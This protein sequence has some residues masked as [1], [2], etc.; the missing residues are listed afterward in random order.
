MSD[1][2][3]HPEHSNRPNVLF[4]IAHDIGLR[5]GCYGNEQIVTPHVDQLA[6]D[7][8]RFENHFCQYPLCGPSRANIFSGCRPLTT[9]RFTNDPFFPVFRERVKARFYSLP[10]HFKLSGYQSYGTGL[11][12]HD[13]QDMPSWSEALWRPELPRDV[14]EDMKMFNRES[15]N[16]WVNQASFDLI[17]DRLDN[18]KRMGVPEEQLNTPAGIR[19]AKGPAFE[20]GVNG[21]DVYF[22]GQAT[23]KAL[24]YL[25]RTGSSEPFFLAVGFTAGHLPW[26]SPQKYWD[27]YKNR[28]LRLPVNVGAP[29]G[30]PEWAMGDSEPAQYYTQHGYEKPWL[31]GADQAAEM[32]RSYYASISYIDAQVGRLIEGLKT[33][34]LYENTIIVFLSDH[35]FHTGEHGYW[36]KHNLWDASMRVPL[37]IRVPD[38]VLGVAAKGARN[39]GLTEH[40]DIYPT[41]CDLAGLSKPDFLQGQ[42]LVPL[43][44][45]PEVRGK[46][47]VFA[48]RKHQWH[49]RIQAYEIGHSIRTERFRYNVFFDPQENLI[50]EELFDYEQDPHESE[51]RA[52]NRDYSEIKTEL[53]QDVENR[54]QEFKAQRERRIG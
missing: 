34:S 22:D 5:Y 54:V 48:H 37:L 39:L 41:L 8:I 47:A 53:C 15:P 44:S 25:D 7:G 46:K 38:S 33:R 16:P 14:P 23:G 17:R 18:L 50:S 42:S 21:D 52:D 19:R 2:A 51:N 9:E 6:Q 43:L 35:G 13:V 28:E 11:V 32:L 20:A 36:G 49:D 40:I 31:A 1:H 4:L 27:L 10:E 29:A 24:E 26:N 45:D 3:I 12:L 30:S